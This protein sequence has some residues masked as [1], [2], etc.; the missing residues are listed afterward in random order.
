MSILYTD[1]SCISNPGGPGGWA[2][3]LFDNDKQF[4]VSGRDISTTNNKMELQAVIEGL[5]FL[6]SKSCLIY[7][8][9]LYVINCGTN[10]WKRNKNLELWKEF[11][12]V[13]KSKEIRFEWVKGHSGNEYNEKVDKMALSEAKSFSL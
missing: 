7:S 2:F 12:E 8:D 1:G 13:S 3:V 6:K 10:K 11:D 4:N 9:S 5:R